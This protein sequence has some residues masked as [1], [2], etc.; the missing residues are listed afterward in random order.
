M[1]T[2]T[3]ATTTTTPETA[4]GCIATGDS[5]FIDGLYDAAIENYTAAICLSDTTRR[6]KTNSSKDAEPSKNYTAISDEDKVLRFRSFTHRSEAY[7][8]TLKYSHAYNDA[9]AALA[10]AEP[11]PC[12]D[13]SSSTTPSLLLL[14]RHGELALAHDRIARSSMGLF[15]S[16]MGIAA[17]GKNGRVAFVKLMQGQTNDEALSEM[18]EEARAHWEKA[19]EL[20]SSSSSSNAAA[21]DDALVSKYRKKLAQLGG[22]ELDDSAVDVEG[23]PQGGIGNDFLA[24]MGGL[25]SSSTKYQPPPAASSSAT[26]FQQATAAQPPAVRTQPTPSPPPPSSSSR[27][28]PKLSDHPASKKETSPVDRGV[29]S[30]MPKYQYYQDDNF[31]KVQILEPNVAPENLNVTF[32][33]DELIVKIKKRE[34]GQGLLTEYTVIYGDLYEEVIAEKCKSIIKDEKVLIKLKKKESKYEWTKLLDDSKSGD[35]KKSRIEK[36]GKDHAAG[37][38]ATTVV[39]AK[40]DAESTAAATATS[41]ANNDTN[42]PKQ[43]PK[44][45]GSSTKNRPYASHRDWNAIEANLKAEEEKEKPEGDEA[46]NKLFQQIYANANEDTRRAM[47]K[48]M[49]TSGGTCLSTNWEEV[50]RTDY[51]KERQAP[52]GMEW[53]NYENEKLKMKDDD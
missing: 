36:R 51:E 3:A 14:L 8:A 48:S 41:A 6:T 25:M 52:K 21:V 9:R 26:A 31:M 50:E 13:S 17:R 4:L 42:E 38:T 2:M 39:D 53:K 20:V 29:M 18:M 27:G 15:N 34:G 16:N 30:G 40:G 45:Q 33:P 37:S 44:L 19:L 35:R 32:T 49:Q 28:P 7:L 5:L 12:D 11:S 10:L 24:K 43:I 47:V 1:P 46:L 22:E 23:K